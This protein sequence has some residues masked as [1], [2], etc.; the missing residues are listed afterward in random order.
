MI[1]CHSSIGAVMFPEHGTHASELLRN[2]DIALY[3]AKD[4]GRCSAVLF[5]PAMQVEVQER[6]AMINRARTAAKS[7]DILAF[8][9]PK[10][11]LATGELIGFEALLRWR[12]A[13]GVIH[14]PGSI[15]AAFEDREVADLLGQ[16]MLDHVVADITRWRLMG[17][18]YG[19][20]AINAAPAEFRQT[21]FAPRLIRSM[22]EAR[23]TSADIDVEITEGVFLGRGSDRAKYAIAA[24]SEYGTRI[25]L[26]DFGTGF[27][28][29][30]HL[31]A[32][33]VDT[34]KIDRSFISNITKLSGD[35]AIVSAII[36]L[37]RNLGIKVVAEGMETIEQ[38]LT[39]QEFGCEQAQGYYF[40]M[41]TPAEQI[42][43]LI[44]NWNGRSPLLGL[45][46]PLIVTG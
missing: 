26:D 12:D 35:A 22:E 9:Q 6:A 10:V 4:G 31:R 39:L 34:L 32:L 45:S 36:N 18:D 46:Q 2:A 21:T 41:P 16:T 29:L 8:Y 1:E 37:G 5:E 42:P 27:A 3:A 23:L 38:V 28:S 43:E 11:R 40:G 24:L 30:T 44:R 33:P 19:S 13:N 17:L 14:A 25:V 20:I 15:M 7:G